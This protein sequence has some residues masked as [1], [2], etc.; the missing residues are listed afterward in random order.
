MNIRT[1]LWI[2]FAI[3][4]A[5]LAASV[6]AL[7]HL[8]PGARIPIHWSF[9][10]RPNGFAPAGY[11]VFMTPAITALMACLFAAI[12]WLEPRR[13]N[14]EQ[15][16]K[17]YRA[18]WIALVVLLACVHGVGLYAAMHAGVPV[19]GLIEAAVSLLVIVIGNYLGK[20]RSMFLGGVRTP[21]TLSS[22]YSWQRTHSLA[23]KLLIA[24]G[25]L[26]F[27]AAI[28]LPAKP[29]T[30]IFIGA[31]VLAIVLSVVAS[32]VFWLRDPDRR[33]GKTVPR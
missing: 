8:P 10:G 2:S 24:A 7:L 15:S 20:T 32:Y 13:L 9:D 16:A 11:G 22:E 30:H 14:L 17:F 31:M 23:G 19:G 12:P 5:M 27:A 25:A 26:G 33:N 29:A 28:S 3:V 4:V 21:W 6:F 18:S 1:P